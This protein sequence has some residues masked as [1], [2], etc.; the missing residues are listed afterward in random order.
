MSASETDLAHKDSL[1]VGSLQDALMH[2]AEFEAVISIIEP[3]HV[4]RMPQDD[5]LVIAVHDIDQ[6]VPGMRMADHGDVERILDFARG[7]TDVPIFIH[8]YAGIS[9]S[10]ATALTILADRLGPGSEEEAL[11]LVLGIR[12]IAVP[13]RHIV[14][15]A[16][17][18]LGRR[19]RLYDVFDQW[20]RGN[21]KN[22]RLRQMARL[23][24][25]GWA[26]D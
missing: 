12:P 8:C 6:P 3:E 16:D 22:E 13:N 25:T 15:L 18:V 21:P 26:L 10:T 11:D 20:D 4:P 14:K 19:N 23:H 7:L 17:D 24:M 2:G 5:H 9:R 1:V